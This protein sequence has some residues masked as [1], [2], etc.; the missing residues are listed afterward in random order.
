MSIENIAEIVRSTVAEL[1]DWEY[2]EVLPDVS[3]VRDLGFDSIS[4]M[5]LVLSLEE[6]LNLPISDDDLRSFAGVA[7]IDA[8]T[9]GT[10]IG[11]L[12]K[13]KENP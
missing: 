11:A 5:E 13:K 8:L 4:M 6:E 1:A 7:D 12:A 3:F 10:L 9:I 2:A